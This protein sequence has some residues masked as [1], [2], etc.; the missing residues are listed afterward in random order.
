M[1]RYDVNSILESSTLPIGAAK[2]LKEASEHTEAS[3]DGR[4]TDIDN[5]ISSQLTDGITSYGSHHHLHHHGW[6]TIAFQQAQAYH[7]SNYGQAGRGWCKQEQD[8]AA[9]TAAHSMQDL[10]QLQLSNNTHN[11]FQPSVIHNLMG[12]DSSSMDHSTGSNSIVYNGSSG[13]YLGVMGGNGSGAEYVMPIS[14]MVVDQG[15]GNQASSSFGGDSEN[16]LADATDSY[17][18]RSV[19]YPTGVVK[20]GYDQNAWMA[21]SVQGMAQRGSSSNIGA[22]LFTVWNDA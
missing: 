9:V 14:T 3:V 13:S 11:F 1:S 2:R 18:G 6:P 17:T 22:P 10:Q 15:N 21:S 7:Y 4:R 12:M 5:N 16:M 8:A 20:E 19:Y